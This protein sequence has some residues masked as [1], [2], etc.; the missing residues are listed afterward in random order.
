MT[1]TPQAPETRLTPA[2]EVLVGDEVLISTRLAAYIGRP[3]LAGEVRPVVAW[4]F[5]PASV[6]LGGTVGIT[7]EGLE[8]RCSRHD[9]LIPV[10]AK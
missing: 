1:E 3:E 6:H 4:Q 7:L 8:E 2:S 5:Y 10:V 9:G